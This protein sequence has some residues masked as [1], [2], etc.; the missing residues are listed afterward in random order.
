M[1]AYAA[2]AALTR[3]HL[4]RDRALL[5]TWIIG[6]VLLYL[7]QAASVE[8][9]YPNRAAL[10]EAASAMSANQAMIAMTGPARALD[11]VGGQVAWQSAAY[12]AVVAG[13]MSMLL[14][15]R[16]T[17]QEEETGRGELVR[18]GAV[19]GLAPTASAVLVAL[20]ANVTLGAVVVAGLIG[21]G[22]AAAGSL[23]LG[24]ALTTTGWVF[25]GVAVVAAQV[26]LTSRATYAV[27][28]SVIGLSFF[29]RGIGDAGPGAVAWLSPIGWG[30]A[31]RPY[32][33]ERWWPLALPVVATATLLA[34]AAALHARRDY[35]DA[36]WASRTPAHT[37][38]DTG[39]L[40]LVW[41][42]QRG[43]VVGWSTALF[44]VGLG[45]GALAESADSVVGDSDFAKQIV[46]DGATPADG[47]LGTVALMLALLAAAAGVMTASRP[48]AE[49]RAHRLDHLLAGSLPRSRWSLQHTVVS[50]LAVV[51]A[52]FAAGLGTGLGHAVTTQD[53]DA[54]LPPVAA[55]LS[56]LPAA[57]VV[58]AS[59]RLAHGLSFAAAA[60]GWALLAWCT[61]V[62]M[63][64]GLMD[65]PAVVTGL[66]PFDHVATLPVEAFAA[67]PWAA[68]WG[69]A[70]ALG[71]AGQ[72]LLLRRDLR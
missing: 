44:L 72:A 50:T 24:L 36:L 21:Y 15:G 45:Y 10:E 13:L 51:A 47:F 6:G 66:S 55:A 27:T 54:V 65:L 25:T 9:L 56:Y 18:A 35:G 62:G 29:L 16:H 14:I 1:S 57:L 70:L 17:R 28:G 71:V 61:F 39:P 64:A 59:V 46:A 41:R 23:A 33:D 4:R 38:D 8:K 63:F 37:D 3:A 49:E 60:V 52:L 43:A 22:L 53:A 68:L 31:A 2:S 32:A 40:G 42:L 67:Q 34:L 12:G 58:T 19:G 48:D 69:V 20:I 30:Q 11:T 5:A 7:S 26:T